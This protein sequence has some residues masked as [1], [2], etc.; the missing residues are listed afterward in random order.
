LQDFRYPVVLATDGKVIDKVSRT[1]GAMAAILMNALLTNVGVA[2]CACR[3]RDEQ[4]R[5]FA[6]GLIIRESE[7]SRLHPIRLAGGC[8]QPGGR[9]R[10]GSKP[11]SQPDFR[12][13]P[14]AAESGAKNPGSLN[15]EVAI[16]ASVL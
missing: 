8:M 5:A 2:K 15:S 1:V 11:L 7:L 13:R 14:Q 16:T 6:A 10:K 4:V 3:E 9:V 12:I